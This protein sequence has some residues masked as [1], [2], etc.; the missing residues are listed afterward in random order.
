MQ[1]QTFVWYCKQHTY[2]Y[3]VCLTK[4]CNR[5]NLNN[6]FPWNQNITRNILFFEDFYLFIC[7]SYYPLV[8]ACTQ[9]RPKTK[10]KGKKITICIQRITIFD[11]PF[12]THENTIKRSYSR[13]FSIVSSMI[14]GSCFIIQAYTDN[15]LLMH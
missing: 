11:T 2:I 8:H 15:S 5:K 1:T 3:N 6:T 4:L 7:I 10:H 9:F 14:R 12:Y 13:T